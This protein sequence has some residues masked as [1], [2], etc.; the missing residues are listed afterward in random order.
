M[1]EEF[2]SREELMVGVLEAYMSPCLC[3]RLSHRKGDH[4]DLTS[5]LFLGEE[6][7]NAHIEG[8]HKTS[9]PGVHLPL[10]SPG[11][12]WSIATCNLCPKSLCSPTF[13]AP[14]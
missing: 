4:L 12:L 3:L 14:L 7:G 8:N 6:N 5:S 1:Q 9:F 2:K 10:S 11:F 13:T